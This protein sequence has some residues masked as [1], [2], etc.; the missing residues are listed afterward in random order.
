[1]NTWNTAAV[2]R[3][4]RRTV[5][6]LAL[7]QVFSGI[8]TG[9][10]VSVGA[11]L[12]VD[13]SGNTAWGGSVTTILTL[14]AM[15]ASMPL[16]RL[17]SARGRRGALVTG[18]LI[19]AAGAALMIVAASIGSFPV[20]LAAGLL[21]GTG[22]A[23]NLQARFAATDL[24]QPHRRGRDLS[25][26]VWTTTVGAVAGP[27]LLGVGENIGKALSLPQ[28][29]GI[30]VI[31]GAGLLVAALVLTVGLRPDPSTV[32]RMMNTDHSATPP[33]PVRQGFRSTLKALQG[34]N[35]AMSALVTVMGAHGIMVALMSVTSVHMDSHG[36]SVTIIGVTI[37]LHIAGMYALSPL[38][39]WLTDIISAPRMAMTGFVLLVTAAVFAGVGANSHL[40][41]TVGLV[42]L[43][44]GW[45]AATI[46][47]AALIASSVTSEQRIS[48]QGVS[49]TL[50][51]G[52]GALGGVL[53][54]IGL[55][56]L[57]YDGLNAAAGILAVV[58]GVIAAIML[59]RAPHSTSEASA[60]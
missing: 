22:S 37:S 13:L 39:G 5:T 15:L 44:L 28:Y 52:A 10:V 26:V 6:S 35:R 57:G 45:C 14:G 60:S 27:N 23:V 56:T 8:G 16:A 47:G 20:L 55:S 7:A 3:H 33:R 4:Q 25:F 51:S 59:R 31:S 38:V 34:N 24:A 42:L 30:F 17:A 21:L 53:A 46:A 50:M 32:A 1:M 48:V 49:D 40:W 18:L 41:V 54:G 9:A 36:A 12:A 43:G 11:L 19:A 29:S 2:A 58:V